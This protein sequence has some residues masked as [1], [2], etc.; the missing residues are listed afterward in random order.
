M[1][2]HDVVVVGA[3]AMGAATAYA[4]ARQ[5]VDV[6]VVDQFGPGHD[7]GSSHGRSRIF[8]LAYRDHTFVPLARRALALWRA[9]SE[10][11]GVE[12]L[13][14]TGG[15]DHGD[16]VSL[17][18]VE[19]GLRA[20]GLDC[21]R[22]SAAAARDR[23]PGIQFTGPALLQPDAGRIDADATVH[24]LLR[25]ARELGADVRHDEKVTSVH[26]EGSGATVETARRTLT[27][28][29]AVVAAGA[30]LPG[31]AKS[32]RLD[33]PRL[34]VTQE[35]PAYFLAPGAET[36][37]VFVHHGPVPHYGLFTPGIGLKVGAHGTGAVV[38]P[39]ARPPVDEQRLRQLSRYV[40]EWLP[41]ASTAPVT[42]DSCL[43][44]TTSDERFV[45][46]RTGSVVV[47]SA[48]S[49]HGFKFTPA[50]GERAAD[51]ALAE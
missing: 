31:L 11:T 27:A 35:Q 8:R 50:I 19:S 1:R 4:L 45:L 41:G 6:A 21:R 28:R 12:L 32:L 24:A 51:L 48:C 20:A 36:W 14:T 47:C 43:Y 10:D 5:G 9:L 18:Q 3:G 15:I 46:R 22:F 34:T 33:L 26:D 13:A 16:Q 39:D 30:W 38:D 40:G 42:V 2:T 25:R 29:V 7:R 37:P 44:T 23:W 17:D 49:G